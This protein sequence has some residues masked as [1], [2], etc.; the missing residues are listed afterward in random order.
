MN[1]LKSPQQVRAFERYY[2][3]SQ[4]FSFGLVEIA[5]AE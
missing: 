2:D 4:I 1:A 3:L 5:L